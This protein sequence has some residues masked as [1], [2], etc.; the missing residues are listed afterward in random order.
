[1]GAKVLMAGASTSTILQEDGN[2]SELEEWPCGGAR[3]LEG[4]MQEEGKESVF[5]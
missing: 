2:Y 5:G 3:L 4:L 1:M